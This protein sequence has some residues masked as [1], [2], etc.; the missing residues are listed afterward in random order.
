MTTTLHRPPTPT[1]YKGVLFRSKTE[2]CYAV[3]IDVLPGWSWRYEPAE[4]T[5]S[6]GW[7]PDFLI[8]VPRMRNYWRAEI[9]PSEPTQTYIENWRRKVSELKNE[10]K[11]VWDAIYFGNL[12]E[13][14]GQS[15]W[16][17]D[18][19]EGGGLK[20][21]KDIFLFEKA[22]NAAKTFRFDLK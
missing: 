19:P 14:N 11:G 13:V 16:I 20:V 9:K 22:R 2:A 18:F 21:R 10:P 3:A 6:D 7:T 15:G 1:E 4:F 8:S 12:F 5:T 17:A